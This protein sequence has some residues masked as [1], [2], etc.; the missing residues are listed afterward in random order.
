MSE[1]TLNHCP[2]DRRAGR[3]LLRG[4]LETNPTPTRC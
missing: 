1:L 4:A 2:P 3:D